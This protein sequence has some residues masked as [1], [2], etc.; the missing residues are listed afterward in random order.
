M[1]EESYVILNDLFYQCF[2]TIGKKFDW[3]ISIW[4]FRTNPF[5]IYASE[6]DKDKQFEI[7]GYDLKLSISNLT[8]IW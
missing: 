7:I 2:E 1:Y 8:I 6:I 3:K 4:K 5:Y